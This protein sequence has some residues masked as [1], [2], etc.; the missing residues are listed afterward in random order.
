MNRLKIILSYIFGFLLSVGLF[1]LSMLFIIKKTVTDRS[2]MFRLM[3]ENNY[4]EKVYTSIC[5][6]IEEG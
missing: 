1:V 4:Y 2:F 6:D 3:D 5:E